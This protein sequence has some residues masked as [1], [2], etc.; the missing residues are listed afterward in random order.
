MTADACDPEEELRSLHG[1]R[2]DV[3]FP[4][5]VLS[6]K[7]MYDARSS[8]GYGGNCSSMETT[9]CGVAIVYQ[10]IR[11]NNNKV[12]RPHNSSATIT[13]IPFTPVNTGIM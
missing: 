12:H 2:L 13:S 6:N 9:C 1:G 8:D 7:D 3:T 5:T 11:E 10:V 4:V